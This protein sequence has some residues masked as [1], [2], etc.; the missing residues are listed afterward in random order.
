MERHEQEQL[1]QYA[2]LSDRRVLTSQAD[3]NPKDRA[4]PAM[5]RWCRQHEGIVV[6]KSGI[7]LSNQPTD[8]LVQ[9]CKI[10]MR[11]KGLE[12]GPV[13][14][15]TQN[16]IT[17][18]LEN[19]EAED[20]LAVTDVNVVV[21]AQQ[22][23]LRLLVKE[24]LDLEATD[25]HIE[26]RKDIAYIRFRK[27]GELFLHAEWL[28]RLAREIAS[29]A[30][31]KETDHAI[32]HFN[33]LVPQNASMPLMI[34]DR[35][36][37]LRLAS[38][39]AHQGFDVVMRI[40]TTTE[41]VIA[42]LEDLGYLQSQIAIIHKAVQMPYG[43]V[44]MSGPTGSGKTTTLASCMKM[45]AANRKVFTIEDPVE[46]T[47]LSATQ[48]PVNTDH[49]DRDFA[50][51]ART[52]LRMDPDV[53]VLGE[54]RDNETATEMVRAAITGHL[55]FSTV[56]TNTAPDIVTRLKDLGVSHSLLA[57][58]NLLVCLIC[59]RLIPKLCQSCALPVLQSTEHRQMI[60]RWQ[61]VFGDHLVNVKVRGKNC[62][63]CQGLGIAGRTVVAEIIWVDEQGREFIQRSD[64]LGWRKYLKQNDWLSYQEHALRLV[65]QGIC[66]PLDAEKLMGEISIHGEHQPFSY[67]Q[68][69]NT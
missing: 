69:Q 68:F 34:D 62:P 43:A 55:V 46:K 49:Y 25:I 40:L 17:V 50:S 59:Q 61:Q 11:N 26:V 31:N 29:V 3:L 44:I 54:M 12:P 8:R 1:E 24:A 27:H 48:V 41:A 58:P 7:I 64:L 13:H 15:A 37:R 6:L 18:L 36:I 63:K 21:S 19:A 20:E 51:M 35:E 5:L 39:P 2:D 60:P 57:S 28:P 14:P 52:V 10:A 42:K 32:T 38:L 53:I 9:N 30:F 65:S 47:I 33:P 22:Q 67:R 66:D 45:V 4:M 56:H 23:R 16:L